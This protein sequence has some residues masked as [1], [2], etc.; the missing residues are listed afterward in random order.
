MKFFNLLKLFFFITQQNICNFNIYFIKFNICKFFIILN[1]NNLK[2]Y[3]NIKFFN[4][5][6]IKSV[7]IILNINYV[8]FS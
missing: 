2:I 6:K 5:N 8:L 1:I 4:H 7:F 3:K